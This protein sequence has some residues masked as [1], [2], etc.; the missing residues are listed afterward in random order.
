MRLI[1]PAVFSMFIMLLSCKKKDSYGYTCTCNDIQSGALDS[2]FTLRVGTSGE[3]TYLCNN[4]AD[5]ANKYGK[6]I[7]C[8]LK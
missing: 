3:A 5:T 8:T 7:K 2:S 6:N 4:V 1:I